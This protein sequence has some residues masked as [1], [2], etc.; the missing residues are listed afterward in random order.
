M[1]FVQVEPGAENHSLY[2]YLFIKRA[3]ESLGF[4]IV[5]RFSSELSLWIS[6]I[7][8]SMSMAMIYEYDL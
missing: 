6:L 4:D 1:K 7:K 2:Q 8:V 5:L 3:L